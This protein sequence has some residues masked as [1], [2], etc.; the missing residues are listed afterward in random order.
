MGKERIAVVGSAAN[1]VTRAHR[2]LAEMLTGSGLFDRVLWFPSGSR[3]DKPHLISAEHRIRMTELVFTPQW[4]EKQATAFAVDLRE[5]RRRSIPTV[6]LLRE[7]KKEY[8]TAEVIFGTGVDVV[9]P[10][11]EYAGKCD[12]LHYWDEGKVLFSDW[13]FAVWPREGYP[14]PRALRE[15]GEIPPHFLVLDGPPSLS[16]H[17]SSTKVRERVL[18][19][20]SLDDL[21]DPLVAEYIRIHGLYR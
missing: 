2:E 12:V 21:V 14:H 4:R 20:E 17:I 5:A 8:P 18:R 11:E 7:I 16:S 9:T 1:P 10:R 6:D 19:G 3:P 13:T 15:A